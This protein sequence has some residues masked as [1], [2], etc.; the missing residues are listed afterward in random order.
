MYQSAR[1]F[2]RFVNNSNFDCIFTFHFF[3]FFTRLR[4]NC[5]KVAIV[6]DLAPLYKEIKDK[7]DFKLK[8]LF[9]YYL[10]CQLETCDKIIAISNFVKTDIIKH[11][12]YANPQKI[13]TVH[14]PVEIT[15]T[16]AKKPQQLDYSGKFILFVG[17]DVPYKGAKTAIKAIEL[18]NRNEYKLI[19]VS[20][21]ESNWKKNV[22]PYI[23][24]HHLESKVIQLQGLTS[25]ELKWLYQNA[26]LFVTPS[27]H[28]GFGYTPIEAAMY[29]CP[30]ISSKCDS[31]LE[32]TM[33]L[34]NYYEPVA[35][36]YALATKIAEV[37]DNPASKAQLTEI[38]SIFKEKYKPAKQAEEIIKILKE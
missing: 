10:K 32:V 30:V 14:N 23:N 22:Q 38:A 37:L 31:L 1:Q 36:S 33:G 15:S 34:V 20:K 7:G 4:F 2:Q 27:K 8:F 18:L 9:P 28:E 17:R 6:H 29:E 16:V 11:F 25:E 13:E 12:S 21:V 35:D 3:P 24:K 19:C 26:A 5:K